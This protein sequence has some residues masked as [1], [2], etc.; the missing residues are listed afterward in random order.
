M[1]PHP[2][3]NHPVEDF[4]GFSFTAIKFPLRCSYALLTTNSMMVN[5][6]GNGFIVLMARNL[7]SS[8]T[9]D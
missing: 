7:D 5:V 6:G 2:Q 3:W 8:L 9:D 1:G 4:A